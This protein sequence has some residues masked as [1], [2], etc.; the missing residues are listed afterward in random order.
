MI[1]TPLLN[2]DPE[3]LDVTET[4]RDGAVRVDADQVVARWPSR[5]AEVEAAIGELHAPVR[6]CHVRSREELRTRPVAE[7]RAVAGVAVGKRPEV[8]LVDPG[9]RRRV[10]VDG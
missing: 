10:R 7:K 8:Q 5:Y 3:G 2:R 9:P 1:V 4:V 6:R